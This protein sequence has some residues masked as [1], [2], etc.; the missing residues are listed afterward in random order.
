ML[1]A[2]QIMHLLIYFRFFYISF[3]YLKRLN[4]ILN[5]VI[6]EKNTN[7]SNRFIFVYFSFIR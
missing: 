6:H 2:I 7:Q 4:F 1:L 5:T 3:A